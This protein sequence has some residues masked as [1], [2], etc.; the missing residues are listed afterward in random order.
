MQIQFIGKTIKCAA[1][2]Q[3]RVTLKAAEGHDRQTSLIQSL[4]TIT[5]SPAL[6]LEKSIGEICWELIFGGKVNF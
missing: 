1:H 3:T 4:L 5:K 2:T 6:K